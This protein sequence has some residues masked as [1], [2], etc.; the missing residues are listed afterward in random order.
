MI[1][2][3]NQ[4]SREEVLASVKEYG[5]SLGNASEKLK[6]DKDVVLEAVKSYGR[7]FDRPRIAR[8]R[9]SV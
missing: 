9:P 8:L 3:N 5:Y 4:S 2:I 6:A 7:A 1:S